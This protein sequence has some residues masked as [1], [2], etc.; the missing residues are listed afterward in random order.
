MG[1]AGRRPGLEKERA[2]PAGCANSFSATTGNASKA[3]KAGCLGVELLPKIIQGELSQSLKLGLAAQAAGSPRPTP[4]LL[5][6][7]MVLGFFLS[8]TKVSW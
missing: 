7:Q 4:A 2:A 8:F 1:R 6:E 5:G 3:K